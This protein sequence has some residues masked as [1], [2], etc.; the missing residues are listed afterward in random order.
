MQDKYLS[1]KKEIFFA[2]ID[3]EKAFDRVPRE[4]LW[5]SMRKLG[6]Q[7]WVINI[8][9]AMYSDASSQVRIGGDQTIQC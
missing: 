7:E 4:V 6:I 5:W 9:K 8:V 1:K 2:F 3:L